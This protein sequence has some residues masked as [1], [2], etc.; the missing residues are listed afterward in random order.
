M[1]RIFFPRSNLPE[2]TSNFKFIDTIPISG[3]CGSGALER[4][5]EVLPRK[6]PT[7][8]NFV[9]HPNYDQFLAAASL[10]QYS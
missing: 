1:V 9:S 10:S 8:N 5:R 6:L 3:I 2:L 7:W 4:R